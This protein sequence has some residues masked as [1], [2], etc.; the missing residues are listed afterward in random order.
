VSHILTS[1]FKG[2]ACIS[3]HM[4]IFDNF[5]PISVPAVV[6]VVLVYKTNQVHLILPCKNYVRL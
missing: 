3:R 1:M 5:W 6:V 4:T 2:A